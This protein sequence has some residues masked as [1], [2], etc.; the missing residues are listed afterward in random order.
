M[1]S[2]LRSCTSIS[3]NKSPRRDSGKL[4]NTQQQPACTVTVTGTL[5]QHQSFVITPQLCLWR[6]FVS[7][8]WC[9]HWWNLNH[10][11]YQLSLHCTGCL[12]QRWWWGQVAL[13]HY[14]PRHTPHHPPTH[15]PTST[16]QRPVQK[17]QRER[18]SW[19]RG[20][21]LEC[22]TCP[23]RRVGC[24]KQRCRVFLPTHARTPTLD[25]GCTPCNVTLQVS[26]QETTWR[27]NRD[28]DRGETE[29]ES[30]QLHTQSVLE[31]RTILA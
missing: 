17:S 21:L 13:T 12:E 31:P 23:E 26:A 11:Y 28:H 24:W 19:T 16:L 4:N 20:T 25:W 30:N 18:I 3:P 27:N 10:C 14:E 2:H 7:H 6:R 8:V 5:S 15:S 22:C 29:V 1:S 9:R